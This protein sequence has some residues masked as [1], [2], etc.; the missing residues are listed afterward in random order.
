MSKS[1]TTCILARK[2]IRAFKPDKID[3]KVLK[4]ILEKASR[5][6]SGGNTQPWKVYALAG[7]ELEAFKA[8]V[9]AK[10][11]SGIVQES[12]EYNIYPAPD[13]N[14]SF[15][16]RRRELGYEMY[17][18]MGIERKDQAAR[19]KAAR[20]N[21]EFF[22]APIGLFITVDRSCDFNGWGHVGMF[23]DQ[24]ALLCVEAGLG[25]CFQEAWSSY[26][27]SVYEYFEI[28]KKTEIL[29]CGVAI[30]KPDM[31]V[32]VNSLESK[33]APVE[34]FATFKGFAKM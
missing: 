8:K 18:L 2:S 19:I 22:N 12:K 14:K 21:F 3:Y 34:E 23:L 6:A 10:F 30:G 33:R 5:A 4:Q 16:Q 17:R 27:D 25:T 13:A 32:A 11:D 9:L 28:D 7:E 20:N 24:V 29:W 1:V 26:A 31:K 15:L